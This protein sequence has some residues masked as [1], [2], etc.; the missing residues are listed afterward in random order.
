MHPFAVGGRAGERKLA[1]YT[2]WM[3]QRPLQAYHSIED[4]AAVDRWLGRVGGLEAMR[5]S[6]RNP[7][8][9]R[10][11]KMSLALRAY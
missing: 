9:L 5:D 10:D 7:Q 8:Q 2:H 3:A 11:F 4:K 1:T 6:I